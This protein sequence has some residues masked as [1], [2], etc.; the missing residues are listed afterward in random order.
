MEYQGDLYDYLK[1][2]EY[3]AVYDYVTN[4]TIKPNK[5]YQIMEPAN[6]ESIFLLVRISDYDGKG[7]LFELDQTKP[8]MQDADHLLETRDQSA[9]GDPFEGWIGIAES[10]DLVGKEKNPY[11]TRICNAIARIRD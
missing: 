10:E 8:I 1:Q 7:R 2:R 11:I 9:T 6:A 4:H 3:P 5:A